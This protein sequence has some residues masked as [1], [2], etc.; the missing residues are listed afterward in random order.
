VRSWLTIVVGLS[1]SFLANAQALHEQP[2]QIGYSSPDAALSALRLKP[3][4]IVTEND[5]WTIVEDKSEL[6]LWTIAKP[7]NSAYP[8]A[9]KR[10]VVDINGTMTLQMKVLCDASKEACDNIVRQFIELNKKAANS[11][12]ENRSK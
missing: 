5:G 8:T 4:V 11:V 10:Y 12:K 9:V 1:L 2:S 3:G 6:A 7:G